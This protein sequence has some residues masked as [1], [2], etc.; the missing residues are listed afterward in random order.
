MAACL[1][2]LI[3]ICDSTWNS[4]LDLR[5]GAVLRKLDVRRSVSTIFQTT[6]VIH[7]NQWICLGVLG[8]TLWLCMVMEYRR[9][10]CVD[11]LVRDAT[12]TDRLPH[13]SCIVFVISPSHIPASNEFEVMSVLAVF[14]HTPI[15]WSF[16]FTKHVAVYSCDDPVSITRHAF[17]RGRESA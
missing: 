13:S 7:D 11:I 2:I 3:L 4:R 8:F 10:N 15:R 9:P 14:T 12:V 1:V 17:T 5:S 6:G 16:T